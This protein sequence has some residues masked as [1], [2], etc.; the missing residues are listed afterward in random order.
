MFHCLFPSELS[1]YRSNKQIFLFY[2]VLEHTSLK[3]KKPIVTDT[4]LKSKLNVLGAL[5]FIFMTN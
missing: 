5:N 3:N 2:Y 1:K 4:V